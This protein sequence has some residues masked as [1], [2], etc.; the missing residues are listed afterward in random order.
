MSAGEEE[1]AIVLN[2]ASRV[3]IL[4][5]IYPSILIWLLIAGIQGRYDHPGALAVLVLGNLCSITC[6]V[7]WSSRQ[8]RRG[9]KDRHAVIE[10]LKATPVSDANFLK[11]L[12][13]AFVAFD[14]DNSGELDIRETRDL[15]HVLYYSQLGPATFAQAMLEVRRFADK[16]GELNLDALI[17]ALCHVSTMYGVAAPEPTVP[18]SLQEAIE[19]QVEPTQARHYAIGG[20]HLRGA[21]SSEHTKASKVKPIDE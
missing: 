10:K 16:N 15:I 9:K 14:L 17:D 6:A 11:T 7:C 5:G 13:E 2:R 20:L 19:G 3:A 4:C 8:L 18:K 1:K 12:A 21:R